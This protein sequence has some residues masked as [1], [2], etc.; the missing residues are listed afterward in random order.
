MKKLIAA[1]GCALLAASSFALAQDKAKKE[2]SEKQKAQQERM[3]SCNQKAGDKKLEGD[4]RKSYMSTCLKGEEPGASDKQKAQQNKMKDC[5]KQAGDKK[6]QGDA[7][8][9]FMSSCLKG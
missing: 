9:S 6:M 1:L 8:K 4:A 3:K 5:N 2:P 7:R